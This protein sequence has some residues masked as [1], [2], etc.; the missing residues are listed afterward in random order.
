[1]CLEQGLLRLIP[2]PYRRVMEGEVT[3]RLSSPVLLQRAGTLD[4]E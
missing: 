1:M 4:G 3:F 2:E